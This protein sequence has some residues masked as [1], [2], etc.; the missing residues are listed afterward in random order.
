MPTLPPTN[1]FPSSVYSPVPTRIPRGQ[2]EG[3]PACALFFF[4][5]HFR[6]GQAEADIYFHFFEA[7]GG[8]S[9]VCSL[10]PVPKR[11]TYAHSHP[12]SCIGQS[13]TWMHNIP[14][15]ARKPT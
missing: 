1:P 15:D 2:A 4:S 10:L 7:W 9:S 12:F 3:I 11:H 14:Q 8:A 5:F 6:G 13:G